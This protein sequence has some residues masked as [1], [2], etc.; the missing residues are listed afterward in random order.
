VTPQ[1]PNLIPADFELRYQRAFGLLAFTANRYIIDHM[2]RICTE[3]AIDP[4][5]AQIWGTLAHMNVLPKLPLGANPMEVLNE[6]GRGQMPLSPVRLAELSQVSGLPRETVRRKLERLQRDGKVQRTSDGKWLYC[7]GGVGK[8]EIEFTRR[9][10]LQFLRT[11]QTLM[12][13]LDM[14]DVEE[15]ARNGVE[16][17]IGRLSSRPPGQPRADTST[18]A[19]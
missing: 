11:A 10:V 18:A 17:E 15:I 13:I 19:S 1:T 5:T 14:V 7:E 12:Y 3:L 16:N 9:T 2:R 6:L 8:H 4:E